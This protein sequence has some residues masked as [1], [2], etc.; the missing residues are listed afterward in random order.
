MAEDPK[1]FKLADGRELTIN[2]YRLRRAD[3]LA[4]REG[5]MSYDAFLAKATG[6]T[7]A[8]VGRLSLPEFRRLDARLGSLL[9]AGVEADPS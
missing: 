1:R 5:R 4:L 7:E 6:L 3:Q 8:E 2:L 9:S